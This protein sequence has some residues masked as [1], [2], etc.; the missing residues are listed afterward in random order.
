LCGS[1]PELIETHLQERI[2]I[3]EYSKLKGLNNLKDFYVALKGQHREMVVKMSSWSNSL[4]LI[5]NVR[6]PLIPFKNRSL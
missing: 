6:S 1:G 5:Y 2:E 3:K 4:G